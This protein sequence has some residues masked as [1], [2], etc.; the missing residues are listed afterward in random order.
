MLRKL[1][2]WEGF[3]VGMRMGSLCV[4]ATQVTRDHDGACSAIPK[5]FQIHTLVDSGAGHPV[6]LLE[7]LDR[8]EA[9][10]TCGAKWT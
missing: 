9:S 3:G 1:V 2:E 4:A 8:C 5:G 10:G 6:D 7:Q